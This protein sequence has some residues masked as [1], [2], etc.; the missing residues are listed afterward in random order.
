VLEHFLVAGVDLVA[1]ELEV[2]P[3]QIPFVR[4]PFPNDDVGVVHPELDDDEHVKDTEHEVVCIELVV[5][6]R[7]G[8]VS[9]RFEGFDHFCDED[10]FSTFG[11]QQ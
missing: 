8:H 9:V 2:Y 4:M 7:L 10:G 5:G 1:V 11:D 3:L 6:A